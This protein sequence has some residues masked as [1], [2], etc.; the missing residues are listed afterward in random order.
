METKP[1]S[2]LTLALLSLT[3]SWQCAGVRSQ[4]EASVRLLWPIRGRTQLM[5]EAEAVTS[6]GLMAAGELRQ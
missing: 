5:A 1:R 3:A 4:S 6:A 2:L